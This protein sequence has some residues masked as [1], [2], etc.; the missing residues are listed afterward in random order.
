MNQTRRKKIDDQP[1][2]AVVLFDGYCNLCSRSVQFIIPRDKNK[3]FYFASLQSAAGKKLCLQHGLPENYNASVIV[4]EGQKIYLRSEA[5]LKIAS[6]LKG[7][8]PALTIFKIIPESIR[9]LMYNF[10]ARHRFR[11]FGRRKECLVPS[12]SMK[13]RFL[14]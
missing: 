2:H 10:I 14:E 5:L 11:W 3:F 12:E 1:E 9:D 13:E 4:I 7:P 6:K 8:W